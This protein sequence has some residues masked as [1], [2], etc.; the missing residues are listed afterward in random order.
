M[1]LFDYLSAHP[2]WTLIYLLI[3]AAAIER[4]GR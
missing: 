1:T 3:I 4:S 2:Y